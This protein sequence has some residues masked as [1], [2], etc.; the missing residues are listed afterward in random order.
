M[1]TGEPVYYELIDFIARGTTPDSVI[2]FRPSA[3]AEARVSDLIE[4]ERQGTVSAA[5]KSEL[6][7]YMTLEHI[8]RMAKIRAREILANEQEST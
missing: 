1:Q 7:R 3:L 5:D 2:A 8:L 4:R 6:D